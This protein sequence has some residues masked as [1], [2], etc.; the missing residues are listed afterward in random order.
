MREQNVARREGRRVFRE[1][2]AKRYEKLRRRLVGALGEHLA[3]NLAAVE[4]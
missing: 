4:N 3:A 1:Q 2:P